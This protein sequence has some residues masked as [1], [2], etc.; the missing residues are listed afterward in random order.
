MCFFLAS[1]LKLSAFVLVMSH[2]SAIVT[3]DVALV[4][5]TYFSFLESVLSLGLVWISPARVAPAILCL[6]PILSALPAVSLESA[7]L[8]GIKRYVPFV[9]CRNFLHI[10]VTIL[11][12]VQYRLQIIF[13]LLNS[14]FHLVP[15]EFC[16]DCVFFRRV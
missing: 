1:V 4:S 2:L 13:V 14:F 7:S 6:V 5:A 16:I 9:L 10:L 3:L 8:L 15:G 11:V 12:Y